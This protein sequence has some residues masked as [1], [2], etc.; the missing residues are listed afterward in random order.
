MVFSLGL[1]GGAMAAVLVA[2]W[3]IRRHYRDVEGYYERGYR[4]PPA[5]LYPDSHGW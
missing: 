4:E 1:L 5:F 3:L 2:R